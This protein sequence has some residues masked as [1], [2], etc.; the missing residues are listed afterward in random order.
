MRVALM[1]AALAAGAI[2][3]AGCG[4]DSTNEAVTATETTATAP[5][6][7]MDTVGTT[8]TTGT[9]ATTPAAEAK[10]ITVKV[11]KGRPTGGIQRPTVDKGD[12][13]VLV[14]RTDSGEAVHLHGYDIE[15]DVVPGKAVRMP[16][17]ANIA[18]RFEV[19]LHPTDALIAVIEVKP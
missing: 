18:G 8:E 19:E 2:A 5:T 17:T 14:V 13:V 3:L 11:V 15:K 1:L 7:T 12:K 16:F 9:T 4:G 6:T 10:V